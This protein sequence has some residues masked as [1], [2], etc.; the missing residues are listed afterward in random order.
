MNAY[1]QRASLSAAFR[2][3][4]QDMPKL[5]RPGAAERRSRTSPRSRVASC[6]SPGPTGSGKSTT[7]AAM[8][9]LINDT[10]HEH[11]LTIEDPIEFL[12]MHKKCIVNQRELGADAQT[13][14]ARR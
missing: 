11:I 5:A 4:P 9:D 12:H 8:L 6:S 10:R 13:F 2:L 1:F 14:A 7:L 3:I